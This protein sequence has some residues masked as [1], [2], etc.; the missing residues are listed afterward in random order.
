MKTF[1]QYLNEKVFR[2][3]AGGAVENLWVAVGS[4]KY[5]S[6]V[7]EIQKMR[8]MGIHDDNTEYRSVYDVNK[9]IFYVWDANDAPHFRIIRYFNIDTWVRMYTERGKTDVENIN[10]DQ[11]YDSV[12]IK[13]A[14]R[15]FFKET[16]LHYDMNI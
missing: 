5:I 2:I 15:N 6:A 4:V 8:K 10:Y 12:N 13:R 7:K 3:K 16:K 11:G 1:K 14:L 9:K